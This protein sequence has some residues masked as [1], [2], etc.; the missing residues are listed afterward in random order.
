MILE[1]YLKVA[2]I[3][4]KTLDDENLIDSINNTLENDIEVEITSKLDTNQ[5]NKVSFYYNF[6]NYSILAGCVYVICLILSSFKNRNINSRTV[7]SSINYKEYNIKL[8]LSNSLF[9]L[10]LWAIYVILSFILLVNIIFTTHCLFYV[11]NSF[12]FTFCAVTIAFLIGNLVNNKNAINGIVNVVALGS[13]FLCGS[14]VPVELLPSSVLRIAHFLPS[15][16]IN[17]NEIL[18]QIEVFNYSSIKPIL[19][20]MITIISFSILFIII[21]NIIT[22]KKR[23]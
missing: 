4:N 21:T 11:I 23:G 14:F 16:Y 5:L 13:S 8:L 18:K 9:A 19:I 10:I 1:R 3:Y 20:N 17:S 22:K 6:A 12:I 2:N 7:V 15:Y